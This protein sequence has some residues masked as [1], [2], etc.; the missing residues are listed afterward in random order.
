MEEKEGL[1]FRF[2]EFFGEIMFSYMQHHKSNESYHQI[3][4]AVPGNISEQGEKAIKEYVNKKVEEAK[5]EWEKQEAM[6]N[7]N[8]PIQARTEE[9]T[10][11]EGRIIKA[12]AS[13][14]YVELDKPVKGKSDMHFSVYAHMAGHHVFV[15]R[16]DGSDGYEISERGYE[17]ARQALR[18]AYRK[19]KNKPRED[20]VERL[21]KK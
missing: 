13:D 19:I 9:G 11:L 6:E 3:K 17:G 5:K 10:F 14:I 20:L 16:G 1:E 4:E 7:R 21:N 2:S 18:N 12:T 15:G 8:I